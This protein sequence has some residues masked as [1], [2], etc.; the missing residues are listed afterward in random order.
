MKSKI[1]A[2]EDRRGHVMSLYLS[3][4]KQ[5]VEVACSEHDS[6]KNHC[7]LS[8]FPNVHFC[9]CLSHAKPRI[10]YLLDQL[11]CCSLSPTHLPSRLSVEASRFQHHPD[12]ALLS[13]CTLHKLSTGEY[14]LDR[15]W[16][17]LHHIKKVVKVR[18]TSGTPCTETKLKRLSPQSQTKAE[19][20][21]MT[22]QSLLR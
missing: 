21:L 5:H 10:R 12:V 3:G 14:G 20:D 4:E 15:S 16:M 22:S 19:V 2:L 6:R 8:W 9:F 13:G 11:R 17:V 1:Q 18:V 7:L